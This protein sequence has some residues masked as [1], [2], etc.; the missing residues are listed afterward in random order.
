MTAYGTAGGSTAEVAEAVG[1]EMRQG[2]AIVDVVPVEEIKDISGYDSVVIGSAVRITKLLSKTRKFLRKNRRQLKLL[3]LAHFLVCMTIADD[4]LENVEKTT[5][6]AKLLLSLKR[7]VTLG[8]FGGCMDPEKLTGMFAKMM[9][10]QPTEDKRD[11][12]KIR[13]WA[14]EALAELSE[15]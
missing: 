11:W 2:G 9:E 8:L 12:D 4:T 14:R 7:P 1:D 3:P 10:S 6:F 5:E 13:A 15:A